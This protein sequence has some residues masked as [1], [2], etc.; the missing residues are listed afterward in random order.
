MLEEIIRA[1]VDFMS[2][3]PSWA[4]VITFWI[5]LLESLPIFGYLLPGSVVLTGI[6]LL[7]GARILPFNEIM[8]WAIAGAI[9]G[10]GLSYSLGRHYH[11]GIRN[12]RVFIRYASWFDQGQLFFEKHGGKSV[13][14][15]RFIGPLRPIIPVIAGMMNMRTSYFLCA[16]IT[17]AIL[18]APAHL[19]PGVALG[20][21]SA[22]YSP[23]QVVHFVVNL[24]LILFVTWLVGVILRTVMLK[25]IYVIN[26]TTKPLWHWLQ[27]QVWWPRYQPIF[28]SRQTTVL[29]DHLQLSLLIGAAIFAVLF[30]LFTVSVVHGGAVT[31]LNQE[32]AQYFAHWQQ[33]WVKNFAILLTFLGDRRVMLLLVVVLALYSAYKR[34]WYTMSAVIFLAVATV[35]SVYTLKALLNIARPEGYSFAATIGSYPSG[36]TTL[37]VTV[38]GLI[39]M[40]ARK[41]MHPDSRWFLYKAILLI[42]TGIIL[43]RLYLG[44][45]WFSDV[46]GSLFLATSLLLAALFYIRRCPEAS[47]SPRVFLSLVL[48][49][50]I[51]GLTYVLVDYYI[52]QHHLSAASCA[53]LTQ[54][55]WIGLSYPCEQLPKSAG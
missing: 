24:L 33:P 35:G 54:H 31:T 39:A 12:L 13:F 11:Q 14:L 17:S 26:R 41:T 55:S 45:H 18:W 44:S 52:W 50:M 29:P 53:Q 42:L 8:L 43:S 34:E 20:A 46:I 48:A 47:F 23:K 32:V 21:A 37:S 19:L 3:H 22:A 4:G 2:E 10:D 27:M 51:A 5:A 15:G 9:V 40:L 6:G 28:Y 1:T 25:G 16:N 38:Y 49:T 36:H 30:A 7:I